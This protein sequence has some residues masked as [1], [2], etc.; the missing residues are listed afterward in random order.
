MILSAAASLDLMSAAA[1]CSFPPRLVDVEPP[2]E[3]DPP[4]GEKKRY[5]IM[6]PDT[7]SITNSDGTLI[8]CCS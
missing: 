4:A 8:C 7:T 2:F 5:R 3:D 6:S 1:A